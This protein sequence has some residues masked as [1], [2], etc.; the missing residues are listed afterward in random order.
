MLAKAGVPGRASRTPVIIETD[1]S[2][3][4]VTR[5]TS[6]DKVSVTFLPL[7][8]GRQ[9]FGHPKQGRRRSTGEFPRQPPHGSDVAPGAQR[10]QDRADL[11]PLLPP[12][13]A[14][15]YNGC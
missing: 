13:K 7:F 2:R 3:E 4:C 11:L 8:I 14:L 5:R 10:P 1:A 6:S 9:E 15:T 12:C